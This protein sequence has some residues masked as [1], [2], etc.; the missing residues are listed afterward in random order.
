MG[1][2]RNFQCFYLFGTL[3]IGES[4]GLINSWLHFSPF[5]TYQP[6]VGDKLFVSPLMMSKSSFL[7]SGYLLSK[8]QLLAYVLLTWRTGE[9]E[10]PRACLVEFHACGYSGASVNSRCHELVSLSFML[11]AIPARR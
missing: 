9:F 7:P 8:N 2:E 1:I 4:V 10:T 6:D 11:F 3:E 5:S